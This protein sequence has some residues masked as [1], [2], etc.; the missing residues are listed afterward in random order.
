MS[1]VDNALVGKADSKLGVARVIKFEDKDA[2]EAVI[3]W[4]VLPGEWGTKRAKAHYDNEVW[5]AADEPECRCEE[6]GET[7]GYFVFGRITFS[8]RWT[9]ALTVAEV[10]RDAQ[11]EPPALPPLP[12]DL[13][14]R[15][16]SRRFEIGVGWGLPVA[17]LLD[18]RHV[19]P[20]PNNSELG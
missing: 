17:L 9:D 1:C 14:S 11:R 15:F 8:A 13:A 4:Y 10:K 20:L 3:K 16:N 5:E 19:L 2:V 7:N 18:G 12:H 6:Q